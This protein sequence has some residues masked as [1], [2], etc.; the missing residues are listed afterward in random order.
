LDTLQIKGLG[1]AGG[2]G[3]F[4]RTEEEKEGKDDHVGRALDDGV[5]ALG[6]HKHDI[7]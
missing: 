2:A 4:T 7:A 1:V 3:I 5:C 6:S